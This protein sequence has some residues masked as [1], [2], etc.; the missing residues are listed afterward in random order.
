MEFRVQVSTQEAVARLQA[1]ASALPAVSAATTVQAAHLA[2]LRIMQELSR[3]S[4]PK[5]TPTPSQ[6]GT[7]PSLVS[8]RLRRS[9]RVGD[10]I[11]AP[12]LVTVSLG[13]TVKY[14]RIHEL[15]GE[16]GRGRATR[17][18]ARPYV[19]PGTLAAIPEIQALYRRNWAAVIT[20]G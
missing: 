14:G 13:P 12:G 19:K 10:P 15:G 9:L 2:E 4:H 1:I 3:T 6:P 11:L 18:P 20:S 17:L 8:V 7:P 5:G 16:T